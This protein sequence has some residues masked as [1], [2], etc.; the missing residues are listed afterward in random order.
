M[1]VMMRIL[2]SALACVPFVIKHI[3]LQNLCQYQHKVYWD[4][5]FSWCKWKGCCMMLEEVQ[6]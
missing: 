2:V 1:C 4:F 5:W 6:N 3:L